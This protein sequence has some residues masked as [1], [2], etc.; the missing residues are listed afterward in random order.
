MNTEHEKAGYAA[1][2]KTGNGRASVTSI[3][4]TR[5]GRTALEA[6]TATLRD[7]LGEL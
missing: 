3:A 1:A 7:L 2:E 6:H 4:L 5:R